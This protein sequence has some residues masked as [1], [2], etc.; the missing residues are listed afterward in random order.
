M[1][2]TYGT[3]NI[4]GYLIIVGSQWQH[5][6]WAKPFLDFNILAVNHILGDQQMWQ[7]T[8]LAQIMIFLLVIFNGIYNTTSG[9]IAK[10][11]EAWYISQLKKEREIS[12]PSFPSDP[13]SIGPTFGFSL[14]QYIEWGSSRF[15]QLGTQQMAKNKG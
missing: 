2:V 14:W 11:K 9:K 1:H 10:I 13:L 12:E 8:S 6:H 7:W 15:L 4:Q 5:V 3:V